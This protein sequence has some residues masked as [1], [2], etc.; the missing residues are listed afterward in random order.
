MLT[1]L[2]MVRV[3]ESRW[4]VG[5][6][7]FVETILMFVTS[8]CLVSSFEKFAKLASSGKLKRSLW[9]YSLVIQNKFVRNFWMKNIQILQ[10]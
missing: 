2:L 5:S 7:F 10:K 8:G 6:P 9:L 3:I 4:S 1:F